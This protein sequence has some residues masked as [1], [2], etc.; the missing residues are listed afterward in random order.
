ML[1]LLTAAC[2]CSRFLENEPMSGHTSFKIGGPARY[3]MQ[4]GSA[5]DVAE[6]LRLCRR[7]DQPCLVVGRGSN[8]L[9][10]DR[11]L[12]ML[13]IEI[14][15]GMSQIDVKGDMITAQAGVRLSTLSQTAARSGLAGLEFAAGIP[16]GVGGGVAMNAGAYGG[17]MSDCL[18]E[19][20]VLENGEILTLTAEELALGY[21]SSRVLSR[22]GVVLSA[23]FR[24]TPDDPT[25][26]SA[27][28]QELNRRRREKQPLSYPSAGSVFKRPEGH[29]AGALI[30]SAGLK[31]CRMGDAMVSPLHA[32]F[33]I[34][35]G[36]A[37]A[38]DVMALVHHIQETVYRQSGVHLETEIRQLGF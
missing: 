5:H 9:V 24:M 32:G 38:A 23:V 17:Q 25:A 14:G 4:A 22:G 15:D 35:M 34:N 6:A 33:I 16:G 20:T 10:A 8:L 36:H 27:R 3:F 12:D 21:R 1:Q 19:A 28:I 37:T 29:F 18:I 31:G 2:P 26:I 7:E 11:G 13:V 30:E